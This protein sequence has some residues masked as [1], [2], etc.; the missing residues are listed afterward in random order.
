MTT[1]NT[2]KITPKQLV[3][4]FFLLMLLIILMMIGYTWVVSNLPGDVFDQ[5]Y[6]IIVICMGLTAGVLTIG[7]LKG[8]AS[9]TSG[10]PIKWSRISRVEA[11][12][13][14]AVMILVMLLAKF[15]TGKMD[16]YNMEICLVN[17]N[18]EDIPDFN[19]RTVEVVFSN[20][21]CNGKATIANGRCNVRIPTQCLN[22]QCFISLSQEHKNWDLVG[23]SYYMASPKL[24]LRHKVSES[25]RYFQFEFRDENG[26]VSN[27]QITVEGI[28]STL[29]DTNGIA[30]LT[31]PLE[32]VKTK[33]QGRIAIN[34]QIVNSISPC[35]G[36]THII[37]IK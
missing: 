2:H 17:I 18:K 6:F 3:V 20:P 23:D 37:R 10:L 35:G 25:C 7:V 28:N 36:I 26:P 4:I 31:V 32:S 21:E 34:N 13:S 1:S 22:K 24:E 5:F 8:Q 14:V 30:T 16:S 11:R 33:Y 15:F 29:S 9:L 19:G 27:W 12:G